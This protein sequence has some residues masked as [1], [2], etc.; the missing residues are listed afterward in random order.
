MEDTKFITSYLL[1]KDVVVPNVGKCIVESALRTTF[2]LIHK[3]NDTKLQLSHIDFLKFP[4][5]CQD[6]NT[7]PSI[8]KQLETNDQWIASLTAEKH[9]K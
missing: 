9:N 8:M 3:E 2:K 4:S 6:N 7:V 5:N 1:G